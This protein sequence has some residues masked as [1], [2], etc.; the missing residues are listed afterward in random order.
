[1]AF[2][3][4]RFDLESKGAARKV[5]T[6]SRQDV[7][8]ILNIGARQL[9]AWER[10]ALIPHLETFSFQDLAQLRTVKALREE[11][12]PAALIRDSVVAMRAV[13]GLSNPLSE[14]RVVKAG[15]RIAFRQQGALV[16]PIGRQL[17]FDFEGSPELRSVSRSTPISMAHARQTIADLFLTAVQAEES[18]DKKHAVG[19]YEEIIAVDPHYAAAFINLGTLCFHQRNFIRAEQ[20]YRRATEADPGYVLA[21]FDLGNVLDELGRLEESI[22]A[23][24]KAIQLSPRYA[25]AHYNLALAFERNGEPRRAL[26]HW[27]AYLK[28]D[29]SGPW[30]E[31]AEGRIEK[32]LKREKLTIASRTEGLSPRATRTAIHGTAA[33]RLVE[34]Q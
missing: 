16:D 14:A 11:L 22:D 18:G 23:Y 2:C 8:R 5:T 1:M 6:Y 31:H 28:L 17:L 20:L 3:A 10:A 24:T 12:V 25:D 27:Q 15:R 26:K 9:L 13:A 32:L 34:A 21:Y 30:A 19:L 33:L 7:L 4:T 29:H